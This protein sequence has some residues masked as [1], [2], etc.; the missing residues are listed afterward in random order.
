MECPKFHNLLLRK[1]IVWLFPSVHTGE[2]LRSNHPNFKIAKI[3]CSSKERRSR[4]PNLQ[5]CTLVKI[6]SPGGFIVSRWTWTHI[7]STTT[8]GNLARWF[9]V[10]VRIA[11]AGWFWTFIWKN[12]RNIESSGSKL[13]GWQEAWRDGERH[14]EH[15]SWGKVGSESELYLKQS[16]GVKNLDGWS[17]F[18]GP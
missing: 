10:V 7:S 5:L 12:K 14:W 2:N 6:S 8:A 3:L 15:R 4:P 11:W 13:D 9:W 1:V 17:I 16:C 18:T